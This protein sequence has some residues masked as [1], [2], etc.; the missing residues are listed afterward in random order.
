MSTGTDST[1]IYRI[2]PLHGAANYNVWHIK[3]RYILIDLGLF[4]YVE[5]MA[6][7]LADDKSNE[8]A[9]EIWNEK[10]H[11]ALSTISL[12]VDDSALVY[13]AGAKTSKEAWDTLKRIYK[14]TGTISIITTC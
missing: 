1:S 8:S 7:P 11:K 12:C 14:A 2:E 4:K 9:I 5:S 3:M 6:P 13:I 10:D